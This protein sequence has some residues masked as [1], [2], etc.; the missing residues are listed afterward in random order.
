MRERHSTLIHPRLNHKEID[1]SHWGKIITIASFSDHSPIAHT[2]SPSRD[3][4][5]RVCGSPIL[6][7]IPA[8]IMALFIIT[9]TAMCHQR[10]QRHVFVVAYFLHE[11]EKCSKHIAP[12][13]IRKMKQVK[14]IKLYISKL[15]T[16]S[17]NFLKWNLILK[18]W[19]LISKKERKSATLIQQW[20]FNSFGVE[21]S[22]QEI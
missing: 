2:F 9:F 8:V 6:Y 1:V 20:Y 21:I 14:N 15:I 11:Y 7:K 3:T 18:E 16:Y 12:P 19:N 13:C 10:Q 5:S 4:T 17:L 22:L